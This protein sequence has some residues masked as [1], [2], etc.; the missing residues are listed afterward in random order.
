MAAAGGLVCGGAVGACRSA[1]E[2]PAK[3][4]RDPFKPFTELLTR[5]DLLE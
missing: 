3:M 2:P 5:V 4:S 1:V